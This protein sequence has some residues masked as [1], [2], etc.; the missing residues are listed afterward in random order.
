MLRPPPP[1]IYSIVLCRSLG[2]GKRH[3]SRNSMS[4]CCPLSTYPECLCTR[5]VYSP[6]VSSFLS[7]LLVAALAAAALSSAV[8]AVAV[9]DG[10]LLFPA[11]AGPLLPDPPIIVRR[12]SSPVDLSPATGLHAAD[13]RGRAR[14]TPHRDG[15]DGGGDGGDDCTYKSVQQAEKSTRNF[16]TNTR[17]PTGRKTVR[18]NMTGGGARRTRDTACVRWSDVSPHRCTR[19]FAHSKIRR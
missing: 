12:V 8:T 17:V 10:G 6:L 7:S 13:T 14:P 9:D 3:T 18:G 19:A 15:G 2:V 1:P 5:S 4:P 11:A 16:F